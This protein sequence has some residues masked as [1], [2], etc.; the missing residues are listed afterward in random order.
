LK[1]PVPHLAE[2]YLSQIYG[3]WQTPVMGGSIHGEVFFDVDNSYMKYL[4]SE[5]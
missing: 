3:D 2:E 1:V 4:S 5:E